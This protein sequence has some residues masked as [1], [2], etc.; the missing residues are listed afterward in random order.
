[1][2]NGILPATV[3]DSVC[4]C[5]MAFL[6]SPLV[7]NH[8]ASVKWRLRPVESMLSSAFAGLDIELVPTKPIYKNGLLTTPPA[9][10]LSGITFTLAFD[11]YELSF[12]VCCLVDEIG[13]SGYTTVIT[14]PSGATCL[15]TST[16]VCEFIELVY[17]SLSISAKAD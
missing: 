9:K 11:G 3:P 17:G 13:N 8:E 16:E 5:A 4:D 12:A 6:E 7:V 10:T 1:M 2:G 14:T 15:N